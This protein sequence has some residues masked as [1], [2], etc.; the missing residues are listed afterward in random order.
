[1]VKGSRSIFA[2]SSSQGKNFD[3]VMRSRLRIAIFHAVLHVH[4][5]VKHDPTKP[6]VTHKF[7]CSQVLEVAIQS[8]PMSSQQLPCARQTADAN[9]H[10]LYESWHHHKSTRPFAET[11]L[12]LLAGGKL[13]DFELHGYTRMTRTESLVLMNRHATLQFCSN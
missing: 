3:S 1:M 7:C 12:C 11:S 10:W 8:Y 4:L 9:S 2:L 5:P 6:C 13:S